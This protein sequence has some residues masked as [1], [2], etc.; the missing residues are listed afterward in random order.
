M[1]RHPTGEVARKPAGRSGPC[2]FDRTGSET[3][4]GWQQAAVFA[5]L[6]ATVKQEEGKERS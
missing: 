3:W 5:R 4:A 6:A 1:V 2:L